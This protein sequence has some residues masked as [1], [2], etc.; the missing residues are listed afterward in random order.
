MASLNKY[1]GNIQQKHA[2]YETNEVH[3][4]KEQIR[5]L[6]MENEMLK[7]QAIEREKM[8]MRF[9]VASNNSGEYQNW[10]FVKTRSW[11]SNHNLQ[12]QTNN[13]FPV[14]RNDRRLE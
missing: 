3:K 11:L 14:T 4:L 6:K 9:T 7:I 8:I 1:E 13:R 10:Q 2:M 12:I 5:N